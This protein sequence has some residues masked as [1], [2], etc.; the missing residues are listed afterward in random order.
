[1]K[2]KQKLSDFVVKEILSDKIEISRIRGDHCNFQLFQLRKWR[3]N[4]VDT[5]KE[6]SKQILKISESRESKKLFEEP[7]FED[8]GE[9]LQQEENKGNNEMEP[10]SFSSQKASRETKDFIHF[11][12]LKDKHAI[13]TQYISID[14]A[15]LSKKTGNSKVL[16]PNFDSL[17][18]KDPSR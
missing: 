16:L 8:F 12:G 14:M 3:S 9:D 2:I 7:R 5:V 11:I 18:S 10:N 13:T 17:D 15:Q 1:M 6:V 4:T